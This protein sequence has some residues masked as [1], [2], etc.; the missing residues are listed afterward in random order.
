[1]SSEQ[2]NLDLKEAVSTWARY[3][4]IWKSRSILTLCS[5]YRPKCVT[6]AIE[7]GIKNEG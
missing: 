2:R 5:K 3:Y 1:M 6:K 4:Q 7:K